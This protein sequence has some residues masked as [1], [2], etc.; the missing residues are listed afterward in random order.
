MISLDRDTNDQVGI[1]NPGQVRLQKARV[2]KSCP[3][4]IAGNETVP[5]FTRR[6]ML[7]IPANDGAFVVDCSRNRLNGSGIVE[8]DSPSVAVPLETTHL[9]G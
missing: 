3:F 8:R 5:P 6:Q 4:P 2:I 9:A 7:A 1:G